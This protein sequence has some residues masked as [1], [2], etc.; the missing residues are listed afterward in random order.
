MSTGY[1]K[2][3]QQV[4]VGSSE[5]KTWGT[6]VL[7]WTVVD[8]EEDP[9]GQ[10]VCVCGH[11]HLVQMFTIKNVHNGELLYPIGNVCVK[12]F[13]RQDLTSDVTLFSDLYKLRNAIHTGQVTFTS[14]YFSRALLEDLYSKGAFTP[15]QWNHDGGY[16][17]LLK[18][19]NKRNKDAITAPQHWKINALLRIK[20]FPFVLADERL[21]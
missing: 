10:G 15:D 6:A 2:A 16:E 11:P 5:S 3:L 1:F 21:R 18:M 9:G 8:L 19:F 14:E 12:K 4:V 17:F 20:V 7:E 13:R